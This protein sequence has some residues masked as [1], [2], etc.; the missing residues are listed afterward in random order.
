MQIKQTLVGPIILAS[1]QEWSLRLQNA[2]IGHTLTNFD[3]LL[4]GVVEPPDW[5]GEKRRAGIWA[6]QK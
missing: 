1:T 3:I 5:A 4:P 6:Y 2:L